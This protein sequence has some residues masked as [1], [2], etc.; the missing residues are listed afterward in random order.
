MIYKTMFCTAYVY[1]PVYSG[2]CYKH[3]STLLGIGQK[4]TCITPHL[5]RTM[6]TKLTSNSQNKNLW[7]RNNWKG[8]SSTINVDKLISI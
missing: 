8:A 4:K 7:T 6:W 3:P 5:L 2:L 1:K